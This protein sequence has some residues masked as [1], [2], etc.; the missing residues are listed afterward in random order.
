MSAPAPASQP[1]LRSNRFFEKATAPTTQVPTPSPRVSSLPRGSSPTGTLS[2]SALNTGPPS[3]LPGSLQT[4]PVSGASP[5]PQQPGALWWHREHSDAG[6]PLAWK[7]L[8]T[9]AGLLAQ[10]LTGQG[11]SMRKGKGPLSGVA[12]P[13]ATVGPWPSGGPSSGSRLRP[14]A[15]LPPTGPRS[16]PFLKLAKYKMPQTGIQPP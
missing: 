16:F 4:P 10:C 5:A 15:S 1:S 6:G 9:G 13:R 11:C 3:S 14:G 12:P 2:N 7:L 8:T